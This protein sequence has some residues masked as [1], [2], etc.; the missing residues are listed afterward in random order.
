MFIIV[1][2]I[3]IPQVLEVQDQI[4]ILSSVVLSYMKTQDYI[5]KALQ[6]GDSETF[7]YGRKPLFKNSGFVLINYKYGL[8]RQ[9]LI[10]IG[11]FYKFENKK[12]T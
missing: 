9:S 4:F 2:I 3:K 11:K 1:I 12:V 6:N 8:Q 7:K 5:I 10:L